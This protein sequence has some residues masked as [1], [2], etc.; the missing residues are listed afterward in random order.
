ME[1]AATG[2]QPRLGGDA[3]AQVLAITRSRKKCSH[4]GIFGPASATGSVYDYPGN[5]ASTLAYQLHYSKTASTQPSQGY[6][7]PPPQQ[8]AGQ[9]STSRSPLSG[10]GTPEGLKNGK[11]GS[12]AA[13]SGN[14]GGSQGICPYQL[15]ITVTTQYTVTVTQA[16]AVATTAGSVSPLHNGSILNGSEG[17]GSPAQNGS[18]NGSNGPGSLLRNGVSANGSVGPKRTKCSKA[19]ASG[20]ADASSSAGMGSK[21]PAF[22]NASSP[23]GSG[24]NSNSVRYAAGSNTTA[25]MNDTSDASLQG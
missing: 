15:T 24:T 9:G 13:G 25:T 16:V 5:N 3:P 11:S 14:A 18:G 10:G 2:L 22:A 8:P 7:N 23:L 19:N 1:A 12:H 17:P 6:A 4:S 20:T 21:L